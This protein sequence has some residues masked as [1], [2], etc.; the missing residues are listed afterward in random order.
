MPNA[1]QM[2]AE[3]IVP[4]ALKGSFTSSVPAAMQQILSVGSRVLVQFG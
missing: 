4:L 3:V 1:E 2:Y